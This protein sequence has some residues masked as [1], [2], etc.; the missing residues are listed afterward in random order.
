MARSN[1]M[2][3]EGD[4]K[5]KAPSYK[6]FGMSLMYKSSTKGLAQEKPKTEVPQK[7]AHQGATASFLVKETSDAINAIRAKIE[8]AERRTGITHGKPK[9]AKVQEKKKVKEFI[10]PI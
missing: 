10:D 2:K 9:A 4:A 7:V 6:K 1:S 8:S 3:K 5:K